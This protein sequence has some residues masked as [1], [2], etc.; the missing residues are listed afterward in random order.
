MWKSRRK[1]SLAEG[2]ILAATLLSISNA[3]AAGGDCL[4][5]EQA[6][7]KPASTVAET[8]GSEFSS[9]MLKNGIY[10]HV[11]SWS[12]SRLGKRL[13]IVVPQEED[14]ASGVT[15]AA[16]PLVDKEL[17]DWLRE[18]IAASRHSESFTKEVEVA[19]YESVKFS[20]SR[21][22]FSAIY[23]VEYYTSD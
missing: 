19:G 2:I 20:V 22:M 8:H 7:V 18:S 1:K 14:S 6:K 21:D 4:F 11:N 13:L 23:I 9:Y 10:I 15:K 12:C 16:L 3:S 17:R 5:K